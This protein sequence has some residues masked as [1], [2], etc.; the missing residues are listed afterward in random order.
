VRYVFFS[1]SWS[2]DGGF[3]FGVERMWVWDADLWQYHG[4]Q[5]FTVRDKV[6]AEFADDP[7]KRI[8]LASLRC[9]G[10]EYSPSLFPLFPFP[11]ANSSQLV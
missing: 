7:S 10:R 11:F 3:G 8:L 5:S 2:V 9:G 6:I 1:L 4:K